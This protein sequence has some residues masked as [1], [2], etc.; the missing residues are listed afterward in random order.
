MSAGPRT[1]NT[2]IHTAAR[3]ELVEMI[4]EL[5]P[6][7]AGRAVEY[8][9]KAL[10][11]TENRADLKAA[12]LLGICIPTS[13]GGLGGDFVGYALVAEELHDVVVCLSRFDA[14]DSRCDC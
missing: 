3:A 11:P 4:A 6:T 12:G 14:S 5:G 13:E 7:F 9:R 10:F 1:S 8:D 2:G